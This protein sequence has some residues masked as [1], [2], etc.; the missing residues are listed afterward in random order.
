[1]HNTLQ[2]LLIRFYFTIVSRLFPSLAV[3]SAHKL[4]HY[5]INTNRKNH[6]E[7]KLPQAKHITIPL[8]KNI[9]LQ[10]YKWG[11]ETDPIV[12]LVH[13][14]STTGRS[15]SH[16]TDLLLKNNYQVVTYD[17]LRHGRTKAKLSD[18]ANWADSVQ[19]VLKHIGGVECIIAHSFGCAAV[20]VASKHALL[21]NKLI[22]IAPIHNVVS[23]ANN[24]ARHLHIPPKIVKSMLSYTWKQNKK[25]FEKYGKDLEDIF[26][27]TFH[28]P[29]LLFHDRHDREIGI[30][31]SHALCQK[32]KW[33][34]LI[35]T[36]G[37][38]HR[39]ILD[40]KMVVEKAVEFIKT[41][42]I[43]IH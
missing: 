18:L 36:T 30:E 26:D 4:F 10:G 43:H 9:S 14:W 25:G 5:P 16:F 34:K 22:F 39:T 42:S 38:G 17:A 24:F 28:V 1:M 8:Y 40:N 15:M 20:T 21:T 27:S 2:L 33:A 11:K 35:Q 13:G 19:T 23:V 29:T 3:V 12:L 32:W 37:L 7:K 31:H 6:H 41:P